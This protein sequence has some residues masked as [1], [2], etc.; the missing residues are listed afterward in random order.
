[1]VTRYCYAAL[2]CEAR[3]TLKYYGVI[4]TYSRQNLTTKSDQVS[5]KK[6]ANLAHY[7]F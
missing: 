1:M 4:T 5:H 7:L 6:L 2:A 3:P